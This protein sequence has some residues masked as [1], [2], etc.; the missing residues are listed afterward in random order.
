MGSFTLKLERNFSL[1]NQLRTYNFSTTQECE[2]VLVSITC[3]TTK[4]EIGISST[5]DTFY[6]KREIDYGD[7][8]RSEIN[9][10]SYL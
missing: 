1:L 8:V 9:T 5:K 4:N 10:A 3:T 6:Q 7:S 2:C